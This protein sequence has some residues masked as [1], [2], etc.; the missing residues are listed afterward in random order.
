MPA[1][2]LLSVG[3]IMG[4]DSPEQSTSTHPYPGDGG[5]RKFY[6]ISHQDILLGYVLIFRISY[7]DILQDITTGYNAG[8]LSMINNANIG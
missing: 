4:S 8:Y 6:R 2:L 5:E 1:T 3:D 7:E